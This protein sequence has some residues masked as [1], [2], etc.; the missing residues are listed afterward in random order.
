MRVILMG[1]PGV[2]KGTQ[3][4]KLGD[5]W[6]VPHISSGDMLREMVQEGAP[7]G[8]EAKSFMDVGELVP[9]A[10]II[11]LVKARLQKPDAQKGFILDGFPRTVD[12]ADSLGR[13]LEEMGKGLQHVL[14]LDASDA[15]VLHRIL[16]RRNPDGSLRADDHEETVRTRLEVY[17]QQTAPLVDYYKKKGLL[18]VIPGDQSV[19]KVFDTLLKVLNS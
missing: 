1:P 6:Q 12:Q 8:L 16:G 5:H 13:V 10:V 15:V 2:G 7:V 18:R 3:A 17:R 19:E 9:D 11:R 4:Q 14:Q